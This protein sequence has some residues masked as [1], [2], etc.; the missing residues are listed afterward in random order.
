MNVERIARWD[1]TKDLEIERFSNA[2]KSVRNT[3]NYAIAYAIAKLS[4]ERIMTEYTDRPLDS[5]SQEQNCFPK[6][7][8]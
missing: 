8:S 4:L 5:S 1:I 2:P 6:V 3:A 7:S